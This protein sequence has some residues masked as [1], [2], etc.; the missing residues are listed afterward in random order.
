MRVRKIIQKRWQSLNL[1]LTQ[2]GIHFPLP[3][4]KLHI[5]EFGVPPKK[6]ETGPEAMTIDEPTL[7]SMAEWLILQRHFY[8]FSQSTS[9]AFFPVGFI[10]YMITNIIVSQNS[11]GILHIK[12]TERQHSYN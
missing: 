6:A 3:I 5:R 11:Q 2:G 9:H 4:P 12:G 1:V 7:R 8:F 10:S